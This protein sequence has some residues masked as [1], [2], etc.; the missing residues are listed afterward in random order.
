[1]QRKAAAADHHL[2]SM[3]NLVPKAAPLLMPKSDSEAC[4]KAALAEKGKQLQLMA[5]KDGDDP[6]RAYRPL[7]LEIAELEGQVMTS[8]N[9]H[10]SSH[11]NTPL[12]ASQRN[13]LPCG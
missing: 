7:V 13:C 12:E 11:P 2:R 4:I 1:M 5:A 6:G 9:S 8:F 10:T 3:A